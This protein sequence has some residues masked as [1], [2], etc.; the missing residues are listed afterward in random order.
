M[1]VALNDD[2]DVPTRAQAAPKLPRLTE[3]I[4]AAGARI[5]VRYPRGWRARPIED[6]VRLRHGNDAALAITRETGS[7][8]A[9]LSALTRE[10]RRRYRARVVARRRDAVVVGTRKVRA[11][12]DTERIAGKTY[13]RSVVAA[14]DAEPR[15]LSEA[16]AV[17]NGVRYGR[18]AR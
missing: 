16:Q 4:R 2:D 13:I 10:V 6:G 5:V 18:A 11:V 8:A 3:E 1:G 14:A 17:L 7:A 12:L 15:V 9:T